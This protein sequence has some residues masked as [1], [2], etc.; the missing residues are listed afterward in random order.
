LQ[1]VEVQEVHL[2]VL[3]Q[4][5]LLGEQVILILP[6]YY[7]QVEDQMVQQELLQE[8]Q[9][10]T[11]LVVVFLLPVVQQEALEDMLVLEVLVV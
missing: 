4:L 11:D 5:A 9:E 1:L 10:L 6:A 2:V 7:Q 8:H 3:F